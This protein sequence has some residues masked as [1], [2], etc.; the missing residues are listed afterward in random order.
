MNSTMIEK[1]I[2][3]RPMV[4]RDRHATI[5]KTWESLAT[6]ESIL[7]V[8]DHDPLPL[9]YQFACE[10]G[11]GFHWEYLEQGPAAWRV[12]ISKGAFDNPGFVP[13]KSAPAPVVPVNFNEPLVLDTRPIFERGETPCA[14]IDASVAQLKPGQDLIMMVPFE[15][16]PL[17]AKLDNLGFS[18]Q[19]KQ[20]EDGTWRVEFK[21]T[22]E[23]SGAYVPCGGH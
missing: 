23:A 18:H 10:H 17:Y 13:K 5:F 15:P 2:D 19:S 22:G 9:Y 16:V 1:L 3:V 12:R 21:K 11:G 7:L 20:L 6:G 8:N 4:P 14:A